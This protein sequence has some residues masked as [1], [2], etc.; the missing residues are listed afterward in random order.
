MGFTC[1][2]ILWVSGAYH[3]STPSLPWL[4]NSNWSDT[5]HPA[6]FGYMRDWLINSKTIWL[7][8][9]NYR[10]IG[11]AL[12]TSKKNRSAYNCNYCRC[13]SF[14]FFSSLSSLLIFI[15]LHMSLSVSLLIFISLHMSV[16]VFP[17]L[18]SLS[19][20]SSPFSMHCV[21]SV[22]CVCVLF[23]LSCTE[24]RFRVY[25]QNASVC[26]FKTAV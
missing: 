22:C 17:S 3:C 25:V 12:V 1:K 19:S 8:T 11:A 7:V 2:P 5:Y 23:F 16:S 10:K 20:L 6:L 9:K 4:N 15:S 21:L 18:S 24:N 13:E 14:S 26:T